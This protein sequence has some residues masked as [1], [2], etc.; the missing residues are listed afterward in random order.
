MR[1]CYF[2][3][4][5]SWVGPIEA[6]EQIGYWPCH[7]SIGFNW[8]YILVGVIFERSYAREGIIN[9][10]TVWVHLEEGYAIVGLNYTGIICRVLYGL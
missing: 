6:G 3:K 1:M 10:G 5:L 2:G 8:D 9:W 7:F 4:G